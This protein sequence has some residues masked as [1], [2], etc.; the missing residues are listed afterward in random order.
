MKVGEKDKKLKIK[1]ISPVQIMIHWKQ[2]ENVEYFN[3]LSDMMTNA[4][5]TIREVKSRTALANAAFH[6]RRHFSSVNLT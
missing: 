2:L 4:A 6:R 1:A 5:R 3:Y